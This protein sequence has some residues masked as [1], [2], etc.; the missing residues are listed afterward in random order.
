MNYVPRTLQYYPRVR[1]Y[2]SFLYVIP[3]YHF[4]DGGPGCLGRRFSV[5]P[6]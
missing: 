5:L 4:S 1:Q 2:Y 6:G 3:S